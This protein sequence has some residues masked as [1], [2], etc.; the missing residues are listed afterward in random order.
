MIR[1]HVFWKY[2]V[3]LFKLEKILL[4]FR[5][6]KVSLLSLLKTIAFILALVLVAQLLFAQASQSKH[7][8]PQVLFFLQRT[9]DPHT[10]CYQLN[11]DEYGKINQNQ[12]I[13]ASV[14][15]YNKKGAAIALAAIN[16]NTNCGVTCKR[17]GDSIFEVRLAAY[18]QLP[19]YL[20]RDE[21]SNR[22]HLYIKDEGKNLLLKR[23]FVKVASSAAKLGQVRYIDLFTVNTHSGAQILKRIDMLTDP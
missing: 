3:S 5:F 18:W 2:L 14:I 12:P 4:H 21:E 10:V 7:R 20:Q 17:L 22:Y 19:M 1:S 9:A 11:V 8:T 6:P 13:V 16:K 23:V 15:R